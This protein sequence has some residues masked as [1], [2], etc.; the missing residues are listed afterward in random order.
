MRTPRKL[1]HD[2]RAVAKARGDAGLSQYRL[3]KRLKRSRSLIS[4]IEGG[5]RN[6]TPDLLRQMADVLGVDVSEL[7]AKDSAGT[8]SVGA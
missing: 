8:A 7:Q 6:A 2:P 3:A 5:T 4:E 1:D